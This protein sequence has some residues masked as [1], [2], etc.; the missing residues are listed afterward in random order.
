MSASESTSQAVRCP[1]C[2]RAVP[3]NEAACYGGAH[4]DCRVSDQPL[5]MTPRSTLL[6][7]VQEPSRRVRC[8]KDMSYRKAGEI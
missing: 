2:R 7:Q 8:P 6:Q 3:V 5:L 4:E 1:V